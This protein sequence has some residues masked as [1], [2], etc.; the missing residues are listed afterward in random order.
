MQMSHNFPSG[1]RTK[2]AV[3]E[4]SQLIDGFGDDGKGEVWS[5]NECL[6]GPTSNHMGRN[7]LWPFPKLFSS[8]KHWRHQP[9][10]NCDGMVQHDANGTVV[11]TLFA[12]KDV[13][14]PQPQIRRCTW[15]NV[16]ASLFIEEHTSELMCLQGSP[17]LKHHRWSFY[18]PTQNRFGLSTCGT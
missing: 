12:A 17:C 7:E 2:S 18:W 5:D 4:Q 8:S 1:V 10:S 13:H 3:N 6:R 9:P 15:I 16:F 14:A 11:C